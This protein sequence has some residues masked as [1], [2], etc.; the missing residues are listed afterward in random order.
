M[1]KRQKIM[2]IAVGLIIGLFI[3]I[4]PT[5]TIATT[6]TKTMEVTYRDIKIVIDD[7]LITPTDANGV[8]VEPFIS[9]GT[10]YL[11]VRAVSEALG[12]A[13]YWDGPNYTVYIGNRSG[14]GVQPTV[15]LKDM[16]NISDKK[17]NI[18]TNQK[19]NYGNTYTTVCRSDNTYDGIVAEYL[20]NMK[21]SAFKG[22]FYVPSGTTTDETKSFQIEADGNIIYTSPVL[23]KTSAPVN[24]NVNVTGY[25]H[26]KFISTGKT[27]SIWSNVT[28]IYLGD[29]GFYQ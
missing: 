29:A 22:T 1:K 25:N 19:D 15:L 2:Y 21:Y 10:T 8:V 11:P 4:V 6:G 3:A 9:N 26:I 5:V 16:Q 17:W 7:K 24:F 27:D 18:S 14:T 23:D 28:L 13:V 12:K 20:L